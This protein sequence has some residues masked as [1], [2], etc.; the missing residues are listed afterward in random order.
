MIQYDSKGRVERV[1]VNE[2]E[3]TARYLD[4]DGDTVSIIFTNIERTRAVFIKFPLTKEI[5]ILNYVRG[6]CPELFRDVLDALEP[7]ELDTLH[8]AVS[9]FT[10]GKLGDIASR[11]FVLRHVY[12]VA[13]EVIQSSSDLLRTLLRL[14]YRDIDL[15][16]LLKGRLSELISKRSQFKAWP[17]KD[18]LSS[19]TNFF[20]F[21]QLHFQL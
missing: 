2:L 20:S 1:I 5:L 14:H 6:A 10:P 18:I 19:K 21:L 3:A 7:E 9:E 17:I 8:A 12:H 11:D 4:A 16:D 13:P 15:P